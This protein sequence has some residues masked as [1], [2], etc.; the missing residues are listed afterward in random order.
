[1]VTPFAVGTILR[2]ARSAPIVDIDQLTRGEPIMVLTP[3]PDDETLGCGAM[4]AAASKRSVKITVVCLT[5]GAGSHPSSRSYPSSTLALLRFGELKAAVEHLSEG[6]ADVVSFGLPDQGVSDELLQNHNIIERLLEIAHR[7]RIKT[8]FTTWEHDPHPDHEVA[9]KI[10]FELVR[11]RSETFLWQFPVWG[12]FIEQD[13]AVSQLYTFD[14]TLF[15][16]IKAKALGAHASQM[17]QLINDDPAGF[18]MEE[19]VQRHFI[20]APEIFIR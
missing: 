14:V 15:A 17:S 1:M 5:D 7:R 19:T 11:Q 10:A 18:V 2:R 3:H 20:E 9:A 12:R 4:I 16:S 8:L 6:A 13:A